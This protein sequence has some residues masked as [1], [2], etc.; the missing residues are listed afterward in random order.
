MDGDRGAKNRLFVHRWACW[1]GGDF[2]MT[3]GGDCMRI[4]LRLGLLVSNGGEG[5]RRSW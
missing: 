4:L 2:M 3:E 1:I 5:W